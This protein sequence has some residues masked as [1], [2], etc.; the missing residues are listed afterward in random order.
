[1]R[2]KDGSKDEEKLQKILELS[3]YL[4]EEDNLNLLRGYS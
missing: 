1:M 2:Y 3:D 4:N